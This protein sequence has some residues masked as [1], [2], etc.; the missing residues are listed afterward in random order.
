MQF[1]LVD[2]KNVHWTDERRT[3]LVL[4]VLQSRFQSKRFFKKGLTFEAEM[5]DMRNTVKRRHAY[6]QYQ[7]VSD[8]DVFWENLTKEMKNF[9]RRA[10]GEAKNFDYSI[11]EIRIGTETF[12]RQKFKDENEGRIILVLAFNKVAEPKPL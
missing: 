6:G 10:D 3:R 11:F 9:F 7:I 5:F 8:M 1:H 2:G 4:D 12:F